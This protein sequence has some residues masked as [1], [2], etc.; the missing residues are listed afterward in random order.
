MSDTTPV[1]EARPAATVVLLRPGPD[2]LEVLLTH[3]P[4]TMAFAA[5]MHVFPGGAVDAGDT[6][7]AADLGVDVFQAAA[8]REL[9]EEAG[10]LLADPA[11]DAPPSAQA[12]AAARA[13]LLERTADLRA[14]TAALGV[15]LRPDLLAPLSRWVTPPFVPRRFDVR[16]F[17]AELPVGAEPSFVGAEVLAHRWLTPRAALESMARGEIGLWVPTSVTLQQLAFVSSFAEIRER[18]APRPSGAVTV[19]DVGGGVV[20]I[21]LPGAAGVGGQRINAYVVGDRN[22]VV[23]D[24]GDPSG[25]AIDA[26]AEVVA[27]RG[28]RIAAI[29]VTSAAPDHAAG[30]EALAGGLG[31][32]I[33]A[34][35]NGGPELAF[36]VGELGDGQRVDAGDVALTAV[37]M[38][39]PRPEQLAFVA[40]DSTVFV[41]D[42][43]GPGPSRSIVAPPDIAAWRSSINRLVSLRARRLMLGHGEPRHDVDAALAEQRGV[44]IAASRDA[45]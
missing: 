44:V 24:P 29:A 20:R 18:L 10:V 26:I 13:A 33:L 16:F 3:R 43:V 34:G 42:L 17:A 2:G 35:P 37:L 12:L 21:G 40:D 11:A 30:A 39:G 22:V 5:D 32:P 14:T 9:F 19:D 25:A 23:I 28:G 4:T 27:S 8:I 36:S 1:A 7:L 41:G 38:P 6:V 31:I 45:G 15:R